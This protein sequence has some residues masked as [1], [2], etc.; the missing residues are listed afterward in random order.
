M[1]EHIQALLVGVAI[2][3]AVVWCLTELWQRYD[4]LEKRLEGLEAIKAKAKL[5][6]FEKSLESHES[7]LVKVMF[8]LGLKRAETP[9]E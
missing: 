3:G 4:H 6:V 7:D 9:E 2:G 8:K 1:S 5:D